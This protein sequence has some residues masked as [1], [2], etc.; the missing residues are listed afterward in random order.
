MYL[1]IP[2]FTS[3]SITMSLKLPLS[4]YD[5]IVKSCKLCLPNVSNEDVLLKYNTSKAT[6]LDGIA[7][8]IV[9]LSLQI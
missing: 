6:S 1:T 9:K 7:P 4:R 2:Q 3:V 8:M 5:Y